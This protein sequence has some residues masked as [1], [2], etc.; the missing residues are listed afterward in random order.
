MKA[1]K[2]LDNTAKARLLHELFPDEIP[3]LIENLKRVC[4]EF[5]ERAEHYRSTWDFGLFG[6]DQWLKFSQQT[7]AILEKYEFNML[8]SSKVFS[9]QLCFGY[10][11]LFVN[12]RIIN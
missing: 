11:V 7:A 12:D 6:F 5:K 10:S 8:K 1:L 2:N 9:D 4:A 3:V